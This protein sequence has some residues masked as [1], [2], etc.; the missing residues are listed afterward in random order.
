MTNKNKIFFHKLI[1]ANKTFDNKIKYEIFSRAK[2]FAN[3]YVS[4]LAPSFHLVMA[5]HIFSPKYFKKGKKC[6]PLKR[7]MAFI[8]W[9]L[10]ILI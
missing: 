3:S 2:L 1:N 7:E 6:T 8:P 10:T 5:A 4:F 9:K